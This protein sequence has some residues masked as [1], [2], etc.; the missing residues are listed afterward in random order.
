MLLAS[1]AKNLGK[2]DIYIDVGYKITIDLYSP[3]IIHKEV[4]YSNLALVN[5][6]HTLV[7]RVKGEKNP[8]SANTFVD[9]DAADVV[10]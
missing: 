9:I 5:G 4:V 7:V 2:A 8:S 3:T 10:Y 6:S 1:K